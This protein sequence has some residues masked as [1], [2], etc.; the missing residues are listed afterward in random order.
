M[1]GRPKV[2]EDNGGMDTDIILEKGVECYFLFRDAY[3]NV[4]DCSGIIEDTFG[5]HNEVIKLTD[6]YAEHT[7]ERVNKYQIIFAEVY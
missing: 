5:L 7:V 2:Q 3:G 4:C 6:A 1:D